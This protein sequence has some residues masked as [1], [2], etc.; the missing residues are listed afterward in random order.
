MKIEYIP[1]FEKSV[2]NIIKTIYRKDKQGKEEFKE[3]LERII[4]L[5]KKEA[6]PKHSEFHGRPEKAPRKSLKKGE[7]LG[8]GYFSLPRTQGASREGRMLYLVDTNK[9]RIVLLCV[10]THSEFEKRPP[11]ELIKDLLEQTS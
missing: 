10:Y 9:K 6:F 1:Y 7:T 5:L 4:S 8:K 3:L 11:D 2:R